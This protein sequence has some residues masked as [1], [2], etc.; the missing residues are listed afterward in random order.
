M[1]SQGGGCKSLP[2]DRVVGNRPVV[3]GLAG[4]GIKDLNLPPFLV[5]KS[6]GRVCIRRSVLSHFDFDIRTGCQS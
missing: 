4:L 3:E 5:K 2:L 6:L 1:A